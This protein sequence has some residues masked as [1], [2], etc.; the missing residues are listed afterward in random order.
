MCLFSYVTSFLELLPLVQCHCIT[1]QLLCATQWESLFSAFLRHKYDPLMEMALSWVLTIELPTPLPHLPTQVKPSSS[2]TCYITAQRKQRWMCA[3]HPNSLLITVYGST[4]FIFFTN[5]F[6]SPSAI[7]C[8]YV[9]NL[10]LCWSPLYIESTCAVTWQVSSKN[11]RLIKH[12]TLSD[13]L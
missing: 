1:Y 6:C 2:V 4:F 12:R 11:W 5:R 8:F 7:C 3:F 10:S 9:L 13:R